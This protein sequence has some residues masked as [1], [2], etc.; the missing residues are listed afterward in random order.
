MRIMHSRLKAIKVKP[1]NEVAAVGGVFSCTLFTMTACAALVA[2][3]AVVEPKATD[4]VRSSHTG[5]L[6]EGERS[7]A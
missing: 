3:A 2:G 4:E 5:A 7:E 1:F 6:N